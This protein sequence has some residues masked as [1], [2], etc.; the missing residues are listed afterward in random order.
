[1]TTETLKDIIET[2][3]KAAQED[4]ERNGGMNAAWARGFGKEGEYT[5]EATMF[6]T[7]Y[8]IEADRLGK[9]GYITF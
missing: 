4:E 1:M 2:A 5:P 7:A 9:V 6:C 3:I 8:N